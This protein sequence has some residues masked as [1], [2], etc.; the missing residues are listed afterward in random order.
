MGYSRLNDYMHE[1]EPIKDTRDPLG[2]LDERLP[3]A[4]TC[5]N[6]L[7]LSKHTNNGVLPEKLLQVIGSNC[8]FELC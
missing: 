1:C 7:D 6:R 8:G 3:P 5:F 2:K 4:S